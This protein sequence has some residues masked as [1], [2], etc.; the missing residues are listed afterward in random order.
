MCTLVINRPVTEVLSTS[1][2][3]PEEQPY[4]FLPITAV[5]CSVQSQGFRH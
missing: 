4:P 2:S 3:L 1:E 5:L